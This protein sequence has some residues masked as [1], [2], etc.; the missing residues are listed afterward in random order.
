MGC[1]KFNGRSF[2][3][4]YAWCH[5]HRLRSTLSIYK[6]SL[7]FLI[8][9]VMWFLEFQTKLHTNGT[10]STDSL[11]ECICVVLQKVASYSSWLHIE[12]L[13]VYFLSCMCS[14]VKVCGYGVEIPAL[15]VNQNFIFW[16]WHIL[17]ARN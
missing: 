6:W 7:C 15:E 12:L 9:A 2:M 3:G 14:F 10:S 13:C 5:S 16:I 17:S 1:G 4:S 11:S 8:N